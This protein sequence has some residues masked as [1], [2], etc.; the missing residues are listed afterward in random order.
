MNYSKKIL[1][2]FLVSSFALSP[3]SVNAEEGELTLS[4]LELEEI[5]VVHQETQK[6]ADNQLSTIL[7]IAQNAV[8]EE[9][10]SKAISNTAF[11]KSSDPT[12]YDYITFDEN[13]TYFYEESAS[14][15]P[16]LLVVD[17]K[18]S[19]V[20]SFLTSNVEEFDQAKSGDVALRAGFIGDGV[21][22]RMN[23]NATGS[24]LMALMQL[25]LA[26]SSIVSLD[27]PNHI[28]FNYGGF[29]YTTTVADGIGSW[30]ADMGVEL[31]NN[32]GPSST[33]YG[34]KPV[35]ILKKKNRPYVSETNTGWD[36]YQSAT[37]D[38]N[39]KEVQSKNGY[40][41]GTA[42]LMYFW[43]NY[44]GKVRIKIDGTSICPTLG[45]YTLK[46]TP[47]ITIMESNASWNIASISRWKL[48]STVWSLNDTGKN[49]TTFSNIKVD[50]TPISSSVLS[51]PLN[52]HSNVT[53][54]GNNVI[55]IVVNSDI[56]N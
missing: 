40:K 31:Y 19:N 7:Q 15:E 45:G 42:P 25:P 53:V 26:D 16:Q 33:S 43:Y 48:L 39:Y 46:D 47:N 12:T 56:Y 8:R 28:A 11:A 17:K 50:G 37:F 51:G 1:S 13:Y 10:N 18:D 4:N 22:G 41:P 49:K 24:Y 5:K 6:V 23:V 2:L 36:Q 30:A 21:G 55:T 27:R 3:L 35:I 9:R 54:S 34:W 20:E 38:P 29:E 52:D 44:N 32:L 14:A